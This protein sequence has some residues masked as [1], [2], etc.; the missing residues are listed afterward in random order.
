MKVDL[1]KLLELHE[2]CT[3]HP[4]CLYLGKNLDLI[5]PIQ[6]ENPNF[7]RFLRYQSIFIKAKARYEA[8]TNADKSMAE[9]ARGEI[10]QGI[11]G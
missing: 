3:M 8:K 1:D 4:F 10:E 7:N 9:F 6:Y 2:R 5:K 11:R